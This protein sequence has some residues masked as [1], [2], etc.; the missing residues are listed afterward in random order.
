MV[1]ELAYEMAD[2][3]AAPL[4]FLQA[5]VAEHGQIVRYYMGGQPVVLLNEP[6]S[7][8]RVLQDNSG[9][10]IK[11]GTPEMLMLKPILGNGL[12]TTDG[13]RWKRQRDAARPAFTRAQILSYADM[14]LAATADLLAAWPVGTDG[15]VT[16][17]VEAEMSQLTLTVVGQALFGHSLQAVAR[18]F[19]EAVRVI[20][21]YMGH[22]DPADA[23]G[24]EAFQQALEVLRG[25]VRQ[26]ITERWAQAVP[27][28]DFL[29][30][31]MAT[32]AAEMTPDNQ[33]QRTNQLVDEVFTFLMAGH[34]TTAKSLTWALYLLATHPKAW[35]QL[36]AEVDGVAAAAPLSAA[37]AGQL[38]YTWMCLEEAMRLYP[39]VWVIS[40]YA[41][42]AET[43][44]DVQ[45]SPGDLVIASPY[46]LHR[47]A[48][49]WDDPDE[50]RPER[51]A[52]DVRKEKPYYAYFPFSG[53]P[54][55]C[56]GMHFATLET[57]LVLAAI[58]RRYDVTLA[59][60]QIIEPEAL[61]TLRP[62]HG[63]RLHF[64]P[65]PQL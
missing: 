22:F 2:V 34:E 44:G 9:S 31:L 56:I 24:R 50:Y 19:G 5:L 23:A 61:V 28:P 18:E 65:R 30:V 59:P 6:E 41:L 11:F 33:A 60:G 15:R 39:P 43:F 54:R 52:G 26:L 29:A 36:Q 16:L 7:I 3:Q 58:A 46:L 53:G 38:P 63:I 12:L 45:V 57:I 64:Q 35:Q 20:N 25:S 49:Y 21:H 4:P 37:S 8:K 17:D 42:V 47:D 10:Y 55:H 27:R 40:R 48:R 32:Y 62:R 1:Q 51:F 13:Q 14:V